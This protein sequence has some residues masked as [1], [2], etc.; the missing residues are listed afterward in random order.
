MFRSKIW[1]QPRRKIIFLYLV[2]ITCLTVFFVDFLIR[3]A[4]IEST[5]SNIKNE[6][7]F[8]HFDL[9]THQIKKY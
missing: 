8:D 6:I 1:R 7:I 9:V 3:R 4:V 5:E 2:A